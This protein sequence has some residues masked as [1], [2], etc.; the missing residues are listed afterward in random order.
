[1][2]MTYQEYWDGDVEM[3]KYFRQKYEKEKDEMSF[4]CWLMGQYV[5]Q[6]V[7]CASPALKPFVKEPTPI[8]YMD[9][10][11]PITKEA[12]IRSEKDAERKRMEQTKTAIMNMVN[13][14][15]KKFA[16]RKN[17]GR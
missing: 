2:G 5:Y 12:Q 8:P 10:P 16:E 13:N 6:A 14:A 1:M 17:D 11:I 9:E 15:N 7:L 3:A 4:Q